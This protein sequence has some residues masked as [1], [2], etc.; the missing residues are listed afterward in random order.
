MMTSSS[1]HCNLVIYTTIALSDKN[2]V[3]QRK[4]YI[5]NFIVPNSEITIMP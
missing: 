4:M 5:N 1:L 2:D 3:I